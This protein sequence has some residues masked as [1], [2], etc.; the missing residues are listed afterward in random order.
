MYGQIVGDA[1]GLRYEFQ[2][3]GTVLMQIAKDLDENHFLPILGGG[4]HRLE[5]GN[6]EIKIFLKFLF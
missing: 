4:I 1:L 3:K 5:A 2:K 6:F